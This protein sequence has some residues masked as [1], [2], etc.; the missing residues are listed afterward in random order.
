MMGYKFLALLIFASLVSGCGMSEEEIEAWNNRF[1][2]Q[3]VAEVS[4][5]IGP[6]VSRTR[7]SAVWEHRSS[8]I[9]RRSRKQYSSYTGGQVSTGYTA[10]SDGG[11]CTFRAALVGGRVDTSVFEGSGCDFVAPR[12]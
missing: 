1:K 5:H 8:F 10:E 3:T 4:K 7:D 11:N 12:R 2:G 6:P 9:S